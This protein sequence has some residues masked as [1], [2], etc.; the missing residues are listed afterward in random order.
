MSI[1]ALLLSH[2]DDSHA[3]LQTC[4]GGDVTVLPGDAVNATEAVAEIDNTPDIGVVFV[5]F[6]AA[7]AAAQVETIEAIVAAHPRLPIVAIGTEDS[8]DTVLAAMRAGAQDFFV[9][10]RD[11]ARLELLLTRVLQRRRAPQHDEH[12]A[13]HGRLVTVMSAAQSPQVSCV[14]GHAAL[15]LESARKRNERVLLFDLSLPGGNAT[16]MF[17]GAQDYTALDL[18]RDVGR[19]DETLVD[20]AFQRLDSGVYLLGLPEDFLGRSLADELGDIDRLLD[21]LCRLFDYVI[22]GVDSGAGVDAVAALTAQSDHALLLSDQSVLRSRQSRTLVQE[23]RR[24][25]A[26]LGDLRL[27]IVD[28]RLDVGISAE[29]LAELLELPF[30]ATLGGRAMQR[31]RAMNAGESMFDYAPTDAFPRDV[32]ALIRGLF[33]LEVPM[34]PRRFGLRGLVGRLSGRNGGA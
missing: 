20:S 16:I 31:I 28:H 1:H 7:H 3:W 9:A 13:V 18:L 21:V 19:C 14:A 17:D 4:L 8:G 33:D 22:V 29:R 34:P 15:V 11:D 30:G 12:G 24:T 23:L 10:G 27:V 6:D 32:T 5:R 26:N 2:D 25:G